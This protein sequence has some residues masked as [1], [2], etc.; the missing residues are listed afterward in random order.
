MRLRIEILA[1]GAAL[2]WV[3]RAAAQS[4]LS[5]A[6]V[7]VEAVEAGY[8]AETAGL[9]PGDEILS[10][11]ATGD[12]GPLGGRTRSP[13]ELSD[14]EYAQ[15]PRADVVLN[16]RRGARPMT[17]LLPRDHWWRV[18]LRPG[19]SSGAA[20]L[21]REGQEKIAAGDL[22]GGETLWRTLAADLAAAGDSLPAAWMLTRSADELAR[23]EKWAEADAAYEKALDT[24]GVE[25]GLPA[26]VRILTSWGDSFLRR[27]AW[28]LAADRYERA[29]NLQRRAVPRSPLEAEILVF[30]GNSAWYKG[31]LAQAEEFHRQ[32]MKAYAELAPE[33]LNLASS[34]NNWSNVLMDRGDLDQA[35]ENLRHAEGIVLQIDPGVLLHG[36]ILSNLGCVLYFRGD[37]AGSEELFRQALAIY[38][39]KKADGDILRALNNLAE[40]AKMRGDLA[41]SEDLLLRA[42][43]L[44]EKN[45]SD[46][47]DLVDVLGN[48][49]RVAE[50][51]G[52][53]EV[54]ASRFRRS[55]EIAEVRVPG[56]PKL[57]EALEH[58][59]RLAQRR[60]NYVAAREALRRA[61][62]IQEQQA[63]GSVHLAEALLQLAA[64]DLASN[65]G[66]AAADGFQRAR[67]LLEARVPS[68]PALAEAFQGLGDV[69]ARRGE[70]QG[71]I[72]LYRQAVRQQEKT[73]AD[74]ILR[75]KL[76]NALGQ[77]ERAAGLAD[78]GRRH[79]CAALDVLDRQRRKLGGTGEVRATF[80]AANRDLYN[81]CLE[82]L[83]A[84]GRTAEAFATLE[85]GRARSFL[86]LLAERDLAIPGLAPGTE[87]ERRR[88][89]GEYD[90]LQAKLLAPA[91][92]G[93]IAELQ[94]KL[95]DLRM[96]QEQLAARIRRESP[97]FAS[98]RYP[99]PL[100]LTGARA[101]L[102][103]GTVLF[104]YAVG[105]ESTWLFMVQPAGAAGPGLSVFR[106]AAG[107]KALREE[108]ESFLRLLARPGSD[109]AALQARARHLYGLLVRP[110]AG[111]LAQARRILVSPD[112]PLHT[113]PF[114][115]LMRGDR[116][117][118]EW[119]PIHS[120]LS[121][122]VY[123]ELARSRPAARNAG[124]E[125]LAAF[126]DPAYPA[127]R[128]TPTDPVVREALRNGLT[129]R[130]LPS[131]RREVEAIAALFP[132][133]HEYLGRE[134]TEE[135]AKSLGPDSHLIHFA[136]HGLLDERF[137]LNS[138]LALTLPEHPAEGQDNGLLQAWEIFESVRLDA[139]LVTLSACDTALGKEMGGEGLVGLTRAFQY[140]GARSVLASLWGVADYSTA[141]FMERFYGYLHR[142]K[143][144]DEALRAAQI[145]QIRMKSGSSHPFYWAAF[146]LSGDWR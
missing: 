91:P 89:D 44:A 116:Y 46:S 83:L 118:V 100:A 60:G 98:L 15:T 62:A 97:R 75:A 24:A 55:L 87:A 30:L 146:E 136:C 70:L 27:S 26:A 52:D 12:R 143:P 54:A 48:L 34:L 63:P 23:A 77:A 66:S 145:D 124:E 5:E 129:L 73:G 123:A 42:L 103:P 109:R 106:I 95:R 137:P 45:G 127:A 10:W 74:M 112:G 84:Q 22:A 38:E 21:Y 144:K 128:D 50:D 17:W 104:E 6:G 36:E 126:G 90:R 108:V 80:E 58:F 68:S 8:A 57:A 133:G 20:A 72:E 135:K 33:S 51:R 113:L 107:E 53:L 71:A 76:L 18:T 132:R 56:S 140:A 32:A 88:I 110:A 122:T 47:L 93:V 131:T 25:S 125:R 138:A 134:A 79:L 11:S 3:A 92:A 99:E 85:R 86:D 4:P 41:T 29:L 67:A 9:Q 59:A 19:L 82:A 111:R 94:E 28:D 96:Q 1:L 119:K 81:G 101:S 43:H 102:D 142:G 78:E 139:D 61:L 7:V 37:L 120:V 13:A 49:G 31:D 69:A 40:V 105:P 14:V 64:V 141:R 114:S 35:A 121:A 65:H 115:A 2:L 39:K 16:G 117:L 130:R